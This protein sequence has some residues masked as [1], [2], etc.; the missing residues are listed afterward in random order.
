MKS[1]IHG[2]ISK[3]WDYDDF[4]NALLLVS[5]VGIAYYTLYGQQDYHLMLTGQQGNVPYGVL[6]VW[7]NPSYWDLSY[8][9]IVTAVQVVFVALQLLCVKKGLLSKNVVILNLFTTFLARII[10]AEQNVSVLAVAPF[11]FIHPV[12]LISMFLQ[13]I[14]LGWS[15]DLS[16]SHWYCAFL[17]NGQGTEETLNNPCLDLSVKFNP[18]HTYS[19]IYLFL[20]FWVIL[21]LVVWYRKRR[22]LKK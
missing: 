8:P 19:M 1:Q 4:L 13:K 5:I 12:F 20:A 15:W 16:D 14:P 6:W 18:Y 3:L 11:A 22:A 21:P 9:K 10:H 7:L 2:I 17:S